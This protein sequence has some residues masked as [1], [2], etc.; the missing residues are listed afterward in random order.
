MTE[1]TGMG[2][3]TRL[4]LTAFAVIAI[5][6]ISHPA[7][8]AA[9]TF[10]SDPAPD[11]TL[12]V[13]GGDASSSA[14]AAS[15]EGEPS[16]TSPVVADPAETP[17]V[18]LPA[19]PQIAETPAE[20]LVADPQ[21]IV[22]P[23]VV[24]ATP[25]EL[26]A[27]DSPPLATP[28]AEQVNTGEMPQ[29]VTQGSVDPALGAPVV[30]PTTAPEA[31]A[32]EEPELA[33]V[34]APGQ[35]V[36]IQTSSEGDSVRP[37]TGEVRAVLLADAPTFLTRLADVSSVGT[38]TRTASGRPAQGPVE[39]PASELRWPLQIPP[40]SEAPIPSRVAFTSNGQAPTGGSFRP[41]LALALSAVALVFSLL[42]QVA[43]PVNSRL[44]EAA[45]VAR[46][47]QPG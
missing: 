20:P 44:H 14:P 31:V 19:S 3:R 40:P 42:T 43:R 13:E 29:L 2:V 38:T 22:A 11:A 9:A 39:R 45:L 34:A 12:V 6:A 16:S 21:P 47:P 25:L 41:D 24:E 17:T 18:E 1:S 27:N 23:T 33:P 28:T 46:I 7:L 32:P 26:P 15:Q 35:S 37:L 4:F 10:A 30:T 8:G 36:V 5:T